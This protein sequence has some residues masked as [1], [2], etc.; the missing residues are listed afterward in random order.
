MKVRRK[1]TVLDAFR[2]GI[3]ATPEWFEQMVGESKAYLYG[4]TTYS[5][6]GDI[7]GRRTAICLSREKGLWVDAKYGDYI[8]RDVRGIVYSVEPATFQMMF[9]FVCEG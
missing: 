3:D 6:S 7:Y 4:P 2:F 1:P 5:A 8:I 9:K